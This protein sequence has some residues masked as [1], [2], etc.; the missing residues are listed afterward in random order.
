M[1]KSYNQLSQNLKNSSSYL[2]KSLLGVASS[3]IGFKSQRDDLLLELDD[4]PSVQP[5][6]NIA[7]EVRSEIIEGDQMI[8]GNIGLNLL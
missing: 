5:E 3:V 4:V 1:N 8:G 7:T 6:L 2:H